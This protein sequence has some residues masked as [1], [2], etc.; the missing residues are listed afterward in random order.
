MEIHL[1]HIKIVFLKMISFQYSELKLFDD[2]QAFNFT[3]SF[4]SLLISLT[5][6]K[7]TLELQPV[8]TYLNIFH[9]IRFLKWKINSNQNCL[10]KKNQFTLASFHCQEDSISTLSWFRGFHVTRRLVVLL[11]RP[12]QCQMKVKMILRP[13]PSSIFTLKVSTSAAD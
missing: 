7:S 5:A 6:R 12:E 11:L 9:E 3:F 8:S 4:L 13:F 1:K 10:F 2:L